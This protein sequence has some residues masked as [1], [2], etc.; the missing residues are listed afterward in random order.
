MTDEG[1]DWNVAGGCSNGKDDGV[2]LTRSGAN[3]TTG[4]LARSSSAG[5]NRCG[6]DV[7]TDNSAGV[8]SSNRLAQGTRES[9]NALTGVTSIR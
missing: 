6:V 2:L 1:R 4:V 7:T 5:V 8:L 3:G 9:D